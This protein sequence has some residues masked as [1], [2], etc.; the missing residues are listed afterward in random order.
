MRSDGS[1]LWDV[2]RVEDDSGSALG[3]PRLVG[4]VWSVQWIQETA[5]RGAGSVTAVIRTGIGR[6]SS[7]P[8]LSTS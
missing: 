5:D 4:A 1:W 2:H 6:R 8:D 7:L 3:L